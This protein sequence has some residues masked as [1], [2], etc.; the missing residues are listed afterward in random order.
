MSIILEYLLAHDLH[1]VCPV[2]IEMKMIARVRL[3][4]PRE[5]VLWITP[6]EVRNHAVIIETEEFFSIW[7]NRKPS[8]GP[9]F[10]VGTVPS[11]QENEP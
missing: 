5:Q 11:M 7:L 2:L 8:R 9:A 10:A 3:L 1:V 6:D 4:R